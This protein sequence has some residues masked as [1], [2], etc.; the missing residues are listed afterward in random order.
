VERA[1]QRAAERQRGR[2][3]QRAVEQQ[4]QQRQQSVEQK[5]RQA[6]ENER[7][8]SAVE[9]Q[10][11]PEQP[12]IGERPDR[13]GERSGQQKG[14][15]RT[16]RREQLRQERAKLSQ[17]EHARLRRAFPGHRD[18]VAKVKFRARIGTSLPRRVRLYPIPASVLA[19]FP[20]Y[21]DYRYVLAED[22]ICIVDPVTYEI[23]D[24]IDD[25]PDGPSPAPRVAQ[26]T[27]SNSE[28]ALVRD[29]IPPDFPRA[30]LQLRLALGG[31]IPESVQLFEFAP[32]V[33]DKVPSLSD[34]RFA[35]T[36]DEVVIVAPGDRSIALVLDR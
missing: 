18:R 24:I 8:R 6:A 35:V 17:P 2:E 14:G 22:T 21:R 36:D 27:L 33:L 28:M 4:R 31:E 25:G 32:V 16:A 3:R 7:Q 23:V 29:S 5:R 1:R 20:Y 30:R 34:Y 10:R 11:R 13:A 19:I 26:L 12:R 15:T 9:R